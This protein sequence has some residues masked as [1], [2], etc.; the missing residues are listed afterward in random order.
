MI[1]KTRKYYNERSTM[2]SHYSVMLANLPQEAG[3]DK[4]IREFMRTALGTEYK[5][6]DLILIN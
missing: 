3:A 4:R 6:E 2:I 1:S 5:V